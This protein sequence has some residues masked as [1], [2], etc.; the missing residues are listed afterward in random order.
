MPRAK[1]E[2]EKMLIKQIRS[3]TPIIS[4]SGAQNRETI[5]EN[6]TIGGFNFHCQNET[7]GINGGFKA[8][9]EYQRYKIEPK[10]E[11]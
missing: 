6:E 1:R 9:C 8:F 3:P 11:P 10:I 7:N 5:G 2:A 4:L